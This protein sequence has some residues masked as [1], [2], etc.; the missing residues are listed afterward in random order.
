MYMAVQALERAGGQ[1][2]LVLDS[3]YIEKEDLRDPKYEKML[4]SME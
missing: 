4:Y 2:P 1:I 3:Y